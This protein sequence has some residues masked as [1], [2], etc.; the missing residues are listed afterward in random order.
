MADA[1]KHLS[2]NGGT[3]LSD[4]KS[5]FPLSK[6]N[7]TTVAFLYGFMFAFICFTV[8]LAFHPSPNSS[9]S[10]WFSN[11]FSTEF[12]TINTTQSDADESHFSSVFSYV[13][14]NNTYYAQE[15][16][17]TPSSVTVPPSSSSANATLSTVQNNTQITEES[18]KATGLRNQTAVPPIVNTQPLNGN[19]TTQTTEV[20]GLNP[21][22][23]VVEA[24]QIPAN[25]TTQSV[26]S[27]VGEKG[28]AEKGLK[29]ND[30]ASLLKKQSNG[31]E[32]GVSVEQGK[33]NDYNCTVEFFASPFLVQEWEIK[34]KNG[35]KKETLRLDLVSSAIC[36]LQVNAC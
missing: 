27:G 24:P 17:N 5:L 22:Q 31:T 3:F 36:A 35:A 7:K 15:P 20:S 11:I 32:S 30:S 29:S 2:I 4:F 33:Q 1:A 21:N 26:N 9:S 14:P 25:S 28:V 6:P 23:T 34:D 13:F 12:G 19:T 16:K 8:F 18:N 10:P